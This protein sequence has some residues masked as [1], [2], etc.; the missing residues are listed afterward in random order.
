[1][2]LALQE[3]AS[4]L[5]LLVVSGQTLDLGLEAGVLGSEA[6]DLCDSKEHL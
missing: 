3:V 6:F 1:M 5:K 2:A 4:V